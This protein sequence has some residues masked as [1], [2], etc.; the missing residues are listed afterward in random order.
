MSI[1]TNKKIGK[2]LYFTY[3]F[4]SCQQQIF[5]YIKFISFSA[6]LLAKYLSCETNKIVPV[7]SFKFSSSISLVE[8]SDLSKIKF[9]L[10]AKEKII[11]YAD[12]STIYEKGQ[13]VGQYNLTKEGKL[14]V[15]NIP[16]GKYELEEIETLE[17]LVLDTTKHE[18]EFKQEDTK[19]KVYTKEEKLVN[20]T[21][22]VEFSKT[23]ITGDKELVGATLTV[24]E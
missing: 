7:Y 3:F 23:D 12:G 24:T 5:I 16:M 8:I 18:I 6:I 13:E 22:V 20:D 15:K 17:G 9:K 11:D 14:E 10:T 4:K 19:T 1:N 2:I 21:T